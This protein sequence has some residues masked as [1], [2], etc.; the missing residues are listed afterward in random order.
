[1][2]KGIGSLPMSGSQGVDPSLFD[3]EIARI[4]KEDPREF[5]DSLVTGL[6]E[7]DP[8]LVEEFKRDLAQLK[9]SAALIDALQEMVDEILANPQDYTNLNL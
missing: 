7:I 4:A 8:Q 3:N 2:E 1:M 9:P 5:G 6:G